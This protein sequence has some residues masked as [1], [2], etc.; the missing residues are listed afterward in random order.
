MSLGDSRQYYLSTADAEEGVIYAKSSSSRSGE[1]AR[2]VPIDFETMQ[3][4]VTKAQE[5]RKVAK[6]KG[7]DLSSL[8]SS[9]VA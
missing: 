2:L 1:A 9:A 4:P 3:C 6:P 8:L 7:S 5:P